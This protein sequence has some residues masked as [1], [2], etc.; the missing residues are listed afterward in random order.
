MKSSDPNPKKNVKI[1]I[2]FSQRQILRA[3]FG[4]A[5]LG[6]DNHVHFIV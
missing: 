4:S 1:L 2:L 6:G 5:A 3:G